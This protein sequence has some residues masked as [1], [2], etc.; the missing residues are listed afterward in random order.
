MRTF[1][2]SDTFENMYGKARCI[3]EAVTHDKEKREVCVSLCN[4]SQEARE[5]ELELRSF[6]CLKAAEYVRM[7]NSDLAATN[8]FDH[9]DTVKPEEMDVPAVK[10]GSLVSLTLAPM[11][12]SFLRFT[13]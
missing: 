13:Y 12:W 11:S 2:D 10:D 6:G 7:T 4:Y 9:P 8:G 1:S 3:N 5:V